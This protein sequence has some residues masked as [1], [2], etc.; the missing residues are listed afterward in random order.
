V[1]LR[2]IDITLNIQHASDVARSQNANLN[3]RPESAQ[4][5]F[6]DRLE[7][8]VRQQEQQVVQSNRSEK[9]NVNPDGRGNHGG[10]NPRK[11]TAKKKEKTTPQ[12]KGGSLFDITV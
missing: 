3:A 2:P 1:A 12:A 7:K 10:Y 9:N 4:Q 11:K 8:E 6:A 5:Q